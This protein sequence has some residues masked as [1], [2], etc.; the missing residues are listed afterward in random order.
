MKFIS[1]VNKYKNY[2]NLDIKFDLN[3]KKFKGQKTKHDYV[4]LHERH[5]VL[6]RKIG[7][8]LLLK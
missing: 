7:F 2:S 6:N 8:E 4:K 3:K 1:F 5:H